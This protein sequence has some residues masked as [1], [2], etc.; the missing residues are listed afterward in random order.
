M[1]NRPPCLAWREKLALRHED[2]SP[3]EQQA[4]DAHLQNCPMCTKAQADYHYFEA[5]LDALSPPAIKPLPRLAPHFFDLHAESEDVQTVPA[6]LPLVPKRARAPRPTPK[7]R[8]LAVVARVLSIAVLVVLLLGSGLLFHAVYQSKLAA[9]PGGDTL[10]N[11]NQQTGVIYGVAWSP[12]GKYLATASEDHTVKVWSAESGDLICTYT[13]DGDVV[14]ALAWSPNGEYLA[15]GG[16]DETVQVWHP[17]TCSNPVRTYTGHTNAVQTIAWSPDSREIISGGWDF[18]A[19]IW[20][21]AGTSNKPLFTL[22]V[23]DEVVYSVA[24]SRAGRIA[25]GD[26]NEDVHVLQWSSSKRSWQQIAL[27]RDNNAV[28][29]VAWSPN[30]EYLAEGN[31]SGVVTVRQISASGSSILMTYRDHTDIVNAVAW[32]PNGQWIASASNDD[33]VRVWSPFSGKTLMIYS[34]HTKTVN[35][36]AWSPDGMEI[37]SGSD[38]LTAKVWKVEGE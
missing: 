28:N 29:T 14:H 6:V 18:T 38:D 21:V 32:S 19:Q 35:A 30:G 26:W 13:G 7:H 27:Y 15:S 24:W 36:V 23:G 11:L 10:L 31:Q 8:G 20:D 34:E 16:S 4:L 17:L 22:N 3:D 12:D 25:I 2:L 9:H 1:K 37:I 33:T 5:R